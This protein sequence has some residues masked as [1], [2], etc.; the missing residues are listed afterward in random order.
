MAGTGLGIEMVPMTEFYYR[1]KCEGIASESI[2]PHPEG[3]RLTCHPPITVPAW[4]VMMTG[5]NPGRSAS[6]SSGIGD[7]MVGVVLSTD[8]LLLKEAGRLLDRE[9]RVSYDRLNVPFARSLQTKP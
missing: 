6:T 2:C 7:C 9:P 8:E 4:M 1:R 5:K 3:D